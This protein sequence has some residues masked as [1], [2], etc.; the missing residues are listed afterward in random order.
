MLKL[1]VLA[2]VCAI[3][4]GV[5]KYEHPSGPHVPD[6]SYTD[7]AGKSRTLRGTGKP[8]VI[9]FW[10]TDC[11][12]CDRMMNVLNK[13]RRD[14]PETRVDVIG[15]YL[16]RTTPQAL[17]ELGAGKDYAMTLAPAQ[18]PVELVAALDKG[19]GLRGPGRDIYLVDRDGGVRTVDVSNLETPFKDIYPKIQEFLEQEA[20]Q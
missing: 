5:Y 19:F 6:L 7:V 12:Y 16:N 10:I 8:A 13:V 11:P 1:A 17:S 14:Y 3:A 15:F 2:V 4:F 9:G 20:A 18:P